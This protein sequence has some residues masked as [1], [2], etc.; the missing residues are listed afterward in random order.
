MNLGVVHRLA[1][2]VLGIPLAEGR[3]DIPEQTVEA[4]VI[5]HEAEAGTEEIG[6]CVTHIAKL[7]LA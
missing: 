4:I 3:E 1:R 6:H 7:L 5:E 2:F